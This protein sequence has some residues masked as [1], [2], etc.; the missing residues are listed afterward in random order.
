MDV[1]HAIYRR[2]AVRDYSSKRVGENS[3]LALL[4]AATQA[5]SA[6]N[7]QPWAFCVIQDKPLLKSFSDRAKGLMMESPASRRFP[8]DL[9]KML[10][11]QAYNIFYNASTLVVIYAKPIGEHPDWDCCFA[12]QNLMLAAEDAGLAT[13]P[14]GLAW[15]LF[16]HPEIRSD[17]QIPTEYV[18]VLPIIVGYPAA[19]TPP[20][21]RKEPQILSWRREPESFSPR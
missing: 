19:Q 21:E 17:L 8:P 4:Y 15:T 16:D 7:V 9:R 5:P 12:A 6:I 18:A 3:I 20:P 14:I 13:C 2:R 10:T 11:D 1:L